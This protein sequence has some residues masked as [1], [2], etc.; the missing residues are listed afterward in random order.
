MWFR[1]FILPFCTSFLNLV[2]SFPLSAKLINALLGFLSLPV[3]KYLPILISIASSVLV[4]YNQIQNVPMCCWYRC[5]SLTLLFLSP[6]YNITSNV[7]K[8]HCPLHTPHIW[9]FL[10]LN[11]F[12]PF[13]LR[14]LYIWIKLLRQTCYHKFNFDLPLLT[15]HP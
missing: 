13:E 3:I 14:L 1:L 2:V 10:Y 4:Q 9:Y 5:C 15:V 11:F 6:L 8:L 7:S 12:L